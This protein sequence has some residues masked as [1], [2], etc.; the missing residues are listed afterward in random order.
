MFPL[1]LKKARVIL[2]LFIATTVEAETAKDTIIVIP[3]AGRRM[4][5]GELY[6][7]RIE[8]PIPGRIL[9]TDKTGKK[10]IYES[11]ASSTFI[12]FNTE[13][14]LSSRLEFL[15]IDVQAKFKYARVGLTMEIDGAFAYLSDK[16]RAT[17]S[18]KYAAKYST[19]TKRE[20]LDV[21]ND[22]MI[23]KVNPRVFGKK[24]A[25]HFVSSVTWGADTF[26]SFESFY[27]SEDEKDKIEI[28]L[29]AMLEIKKSNIKGEV[30]GKLNITD[31]TKDVSSKTEVKV[32]GD[33]RMD[34]EIPQTPE[35]A[36]KF[37]KELPSLTDTLLYSNGTGVP[38]EITLTP[39][40][41]I[42]SNAAKL[43]RRI[44]ADT[45]EQLLKIYDTLEE[46][47]TRILDAL[48]LKYHG[49]TVWKANMDS[50]Y[51]SFKDYQVSLSLNINKATMA[52]LSDEGGMD[53]FTTIEQEYYD[54]TNRFNLM[55]VLEETEEREDELKNLIALG[56]QFDDAGIIFAE[57]L[58]EFYAPTFDSTFDR[59]YGLVIVGLNPHRHRDS[60]SLVRDFVD[61]A[62]AQRYDNISGLDPKINHCEIHVVDGN[63]ECVHTEAFVAIHFDSYCA[64]MCDPRF[65][66]PG[67]NYK[68][69]CYNSEDVMTSEHHIDNNLNP[70]S[71]CWCHAPETQIL[72]FVENRNPERLTDALPRVP[73][74]PVIEEIKGDSET[75]MELFGTKQEI[76]LNIN[77]IDPN[78][79]NWK[80]IVE[81]TEPD[82]KPN[83]DIDF[84]IR[85]RLIYTRS[86]LGRV[87][88]RNLWAGQMYDI[89]VAGKN[90]VGLGRKS[91]RKRVQVGHRIVDVDLSIGTKQF[92]NALTIPSWI[93]TIT[94]NLTL[95]IETFSS[96]MTV[97]LHKDHSIDSV[98]QLYYV[99]VDHSNEFAECLE[100]KAF[101]FS[102]AEC[103]LK[104][105][106]DLT[107]DTA[108][109]LRIWDDAELLIAK[110]TLNVLAPSADNCEK[111]GDHFFFCPSQNPPTC[112]KDCVTDC[113]S[114]TSSVGGACV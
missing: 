68:G 96:V 81:Y 62:T 97:T 77:G 61:L 44:E 52:Y 2:L 12:E 6:D 63:P 35:E 88:I 27:N 110:N 56:S 105:M 47:D 71:D 25:T 49:F 20:S 26:V 50:Y 80:V 69:S 37:I 111:Y 75:E 19:R 86:N 87:F 94:M 109:E 58:K 104:N 48:T 33:L 5:L 89:Y 103:S 46:S 4:R 76:E 51:K 9:N 16:K 54:E 38:M 74:K 100:L 34:R 13:S 108:M 82:E 11:P 21:F 28:G 29:D 101:G 98:D 55:S 57:H 17:N 18:I 22:I 40:S 42:D 79:Q 24:I 78:T 32:F 15:D 53:A 85:Q 91:D 83:G 59:V 39:L 41:W 1:C 67:G 31:I 43:S 14:T 112:V 93:P 102:G 65:C 84:L 106:D 90:G 113:A 73:K 107:I 92:T 72:Q 3:D 30:H 23:D 36:M 45:L 8:T 114:S 95:S 10:F 70:L 99:D 64:D 7:A 66:I 60:M